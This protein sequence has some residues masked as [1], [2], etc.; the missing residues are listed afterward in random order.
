MTMKKIIKGILFFIALSAMTI[1]FAM[2]LA[3]FN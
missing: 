1:I 2:A 3:I